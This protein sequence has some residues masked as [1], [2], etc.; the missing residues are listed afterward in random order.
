MRYPGILSLLWTLLSGFSGL[1]AEPAITLVDLNSLDLRA[2]E[3][4]AT[5]DPALV[6]R[7]SGKAL[8][9][10]F[11][12]EDPLP[13]IVL[14]AST[15]QWGLSGNLYVAF[16]AVNHSDE[17]VLITCRVDSERWSQAEM[18]SIAHTIPS[19]PR[20]ARWGTT[21]TGFGWKGSRERHE[22]QSW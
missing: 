14:P 11:G 4:S 2:V 7:G 19:S 15:G 22:S 5:V 8:Q 13:F 17:E 16:H 1:S 20:Y 10:R 21:C 12:A 18:L 6:S 3:S 9:L